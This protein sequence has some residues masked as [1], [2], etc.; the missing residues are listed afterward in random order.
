MEQNCFGTKLKVGL[1][2]FETT[3]NNNFFCAISPSKRVVRGQDW[4]ETRPVRYSTS[5]GHGTRL[6]WDKCGWCGTRCTVTGVEQ[7][8]GSDWCGT[9]PIQCGTSV[10]HGT[11]LLWDKCGWCGTRCTV[12]DVEQGAGSDWCGT[13]PI[14]YSTSVGH[15]TRLLWDKCG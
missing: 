13:R 2:W 4:C 6:L 11:R 9:R 15:G 1:H 3:H 5:L 7:D 10:E 8:A 14:Q 12:T